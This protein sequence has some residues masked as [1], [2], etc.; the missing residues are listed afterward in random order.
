[1]AVRSDAAT[2]KFKDRL[3]RDFRM[4]R[5]LSTLLCL[6]RVHGPRERVLEVPELERLFMA[7]V[8]LVFEVVQYPRWGRYFASGA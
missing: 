2:E 4:T 1:V 7:R 8:A 5:R 6:G 3:S